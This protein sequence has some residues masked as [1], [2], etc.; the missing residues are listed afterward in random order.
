MNTTLT[1]TGLVPLLPEIVLG[2]G[3]LALLMLG[4]YSGERNVV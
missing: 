3:A 2:I 4:V 1:I